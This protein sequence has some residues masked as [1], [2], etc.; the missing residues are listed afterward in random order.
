MDTTAL[1]E[2][3]CDYIRVADEKKL[4]AIYTI[5]EDEITEETEWWKD[6][7][8]IGELDNRYE[9][10]Q[11]GNEK[12]YTLNEVDIAIKQLKEKRRAK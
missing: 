2:K 11:K 12:A 4:K 7:V 10:W 3:L 9:A 8:F 6:H 5:L 1:R